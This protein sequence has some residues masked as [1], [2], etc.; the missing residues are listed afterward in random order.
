MGICTSEVYVQIISLEPV[1]GLAELETRA[2]LWDGQELDQLGSTLPQQVSAGLKQM[3]GQT[4]PGTDG[5]EAN[6]GGIFT[7]PMV[8]QY[9]AGKRGG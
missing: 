3:P 2:R 9:L 5:K 8:I 1:S 4:H 6:G 7:W